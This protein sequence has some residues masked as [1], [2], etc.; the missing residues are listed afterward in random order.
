[1]ALGIRL[2][3]VDLLSNAASD[4]REEDK[5]PANQRKHQNFFLHEDG[6]NLNQ[7]KLS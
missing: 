3:L 6:Q 4:N 1:L 5:D 2:E 7:I